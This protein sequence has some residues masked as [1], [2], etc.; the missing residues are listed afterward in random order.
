MRPLGVID[1]LMTGFDIVSRRL[2][3]IA[4]P[5]LLDLFLW[6]GPRLSA[7]P[8]LKGLVAF[9]R[10]QPVPDST[11]A[12]Q[13]AEATR[14]L[15][16]VGEHVN[17]L[18]LLSR[19]PL[20]NV[21][22]LLAWRMPASP[23]GKPQEILITGPL[24]L[25]GWGI[26]LIPIGLVLGFLYLNSLARHIRGRRSSDEQKPAQD[27][28]REPEQAIVE[29]GSTWRCIRVLLF[30]TG[31]LVTGMM[32]TPPWLLLVGIAEALTPGLGFWLLIFSIGLAGYLGLHLLFVIPGV[33]VGGRGLWQATWESI[34]LIHTQ[35][36]SVMGLILL[37]AVIYGGLSYVWLLPPTDSWS[38]LVGVVG[39]GCIATGLTAAAF[40]FYQERI[41]QLMEMFQAAAKS[42]VQDGKERANG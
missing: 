26:L 30:A 19:L 36:F 28:T 24:P 42:G 2:W 10:T 1:C 11:T 35:L 33:M 21:P 31:L 20:L 18:A 8:L 4:L 5:V 7:A 23:L 40:V 13:L 14:L 29:K 16:Q 25:A 6:L 39:N 32:I 9:L 22:S 34:G 38:L 27:E 12:S 17:L 3:L 41:G 37:T 15:E